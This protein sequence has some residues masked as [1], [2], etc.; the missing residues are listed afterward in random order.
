MPLAGY[1]SQ[2]KARLRPCPGEV[3]VCLRTRSLPAPD[4]FLAPAAAS[5]GLA[6]SVEAAGGGVWTHIHCTREPTAAS[7]FF[8]N[9]EFPYDKKERLLL[10][11]T[12]PLASIN[13]AAGVSS[14][15]VLR[16]RAPWYPGSGSGA[17]ALGTVRTGAGADPDPPRPLLPF[18]KVR[19]RPHS[20]QSSCGPSSAPSPDSC[21]GHFLLPGK[22]HAFSTG[23]CLPPSWNHPFRFCDLAQAQKLS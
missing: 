15:A 18:F 5:W 17:P 11:L 9:L 8:F 10:D 7:G 6:R 2:R 16:G 23:H 1:R 13:N 14:G 3:F 22:L 12:E 21:A 20:H 19:G 4:W